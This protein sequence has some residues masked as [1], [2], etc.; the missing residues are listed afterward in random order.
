MANRICLDNNICECCLVTGPKLFDMQKFQFQIDGPS[1]TISYFECFTTCVPTAPE[2]ALR[3]K[4]CSSCASQLQ[5]TFKFLQKCKESQKVLATGRKKKR[6]RQPLS[7]TSSSSNSVAA[8]ES[9]STIYTDCY[10]TPPQPIGAECM[11]V[12]SPSYSPLSQPAVVERQSSESSIELMMIDPNA[13][14]P[15][16]EIE[17]EETD[18]E[19]LER[20][21]ATQRQKP[22]KRRRA[23]RRNLD[24]TQPQLLF[25]S[26]ED[27]MGIFEE[28][29]TWY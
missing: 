8:T 24:G 29:L 1:K 7:Q 11:D 15:T 13:P 17:I 23:A 16:E 14:R 25:S 2:P 26:D 9:T 22:K 20:R 6:R 5:A 28:F 18:E 27:N 21:L 12:E 3:P 19:E 4:I 10:L